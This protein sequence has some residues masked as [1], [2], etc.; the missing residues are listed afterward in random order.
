MQIGI[1]AYRILI[2]I[3]RQGIIH[4]AL[5]QTGSNSLRFNLNI[6]S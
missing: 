4:A 2:N 6:L 5:Y 3:N 1:Q